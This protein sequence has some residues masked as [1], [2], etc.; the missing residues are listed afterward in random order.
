MSRLERYKYDGLSRRDGLRLLELHPAN[1]T[2]PEIDC[3][4]LE[5]RLIDPYSTQ[6][7]G[8]EIVKYEAVLW[9]WG[10]QVFSSI[11]RIHKNSRVYEFLIVP[12]LESALRALRHSDRNRILWIDAVCIY[13]RRTAT[14]CC[15]NLR[16]R[17]QFCEGFGFCLA[18]P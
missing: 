11:L 9:C 1:L 12:N 5:S 10:P 14:K 16:F 15:R 8:Q 2:Q 13:S 6:P 7:V 3:T 4:L 17:P 18:L